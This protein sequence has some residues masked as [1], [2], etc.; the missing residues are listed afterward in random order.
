VTA[1]ASAGSAVS[2]IVRRELLPLRRAQSACTIGDLMD[3]ASAPDPYPLL[4]H[5]YEWYFVRT[6]TAIRTAYTVAGGLSAALFG[7]IYKKP[8]DD[9]RWGEDVLQWGL[10]MLIVLSAVSGIYQ[11]RLLAQLHRELAVAARLVTKLRDLPGLDVVTPPK[12]ET[13]ST[14]RKR[15]REVLQYLAGLV[16]SGAIAGL[17]LL[18]RGGDDA[19]D[20]VLMLVAGVVA[21]PLLWHLAVEIWPSQPEGVNARI[22][23]LRDQ[24]GH[25]RLDVYIDQRGIADDVDF[26]IAQV[27]ESQSPL[28]ADSGTT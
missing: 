20:V 12:V 15:R 8:P 2:Q 25:V 17:I 7:L 16:L 19:P 3:L 10:A 22:G 14:A 4:E 9:L 13:G 21:I 1:K 28:S 27:R 23:S 5:I 11:A 26:F 18:I 6:T 24:I